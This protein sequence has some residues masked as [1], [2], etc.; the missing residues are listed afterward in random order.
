M[1]DDLL[2]AN[3]IDAATGRP[4]LPVVAA[5]TVAKV[6]RGETLTDA[7]LAELDYKRRQAAGG[8][9]TRPTVSS[10]GSSRTTWARP[11]GA[12]SR[13]PRMRPR[14]RRS[15][16]RWRRC[17]RCVR[18]RRAT[19]TGSTTA[20]WPSFPA[21]PRTAGW[22]ARAASRGRWTRQDTV[23]PADPGQPREDPLSLPVSAR[24][25][26]RGGPPLVRRPDA[27]DRYASY[28]QTVVAAETG[29]L[30]GQSWSL[31]RKAAF[32]GV[33][34]DGDTATGLS[35]EYLVK[36]LAA[37]PGRGPAVVAGRRP[38][39]T[40]RPTRPAWPA[41]SA[42][43]TRR[44]CSSPPATASV[45]PRATSCSAATR[46]RCSAGTGPA[47][48]AGTSAIPE[49][50]YFSAD[51]VAD[52][53]RLLGL[54]AFHF[55]CYGAGTPRL[56]EFAHRA[57]LAAQAQIA[58]C[59]FLAGL[60][61]RLLGHPQR[62]R[63]GGHRP[64]GSR[65]GLLLHLGRHQQPAHRVQEH[66]EMPGRRAARRLRHGILQRT[67]RRDLHGAQREIEDIKFGAEPDERE[68]AGLWTA[69]ND[70][71]GY[72]VVGDPAV[73]LPLAAV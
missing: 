27:L 30:A 55:A 43:T 14:C 17:W 46:A 9:D 31:P 53:A 20:S 15:A 62:R 60:P 8:E 33:R 38:A 2:Y 34:N 40:S 54:I 47:R 69:N 19:A 3:G 67:L 32:F 29:Q 71:R 61:Q 35:A 22:A 1:P 72:I 63:A 49:T 5:G 7:E 50:F 52:D 25:A 45:S 37:V 13:R 23:L 64:R 12:S 39:W 57:G 6:A 48:T 56:D 18:H 11:V 16:K 28:A 24:R 36:P 59:D 66:A 10:R 44:R 21:T 70:A 41:C 68:L 65:L 73:R 42:A 51:D 58:P 4:L 26:V